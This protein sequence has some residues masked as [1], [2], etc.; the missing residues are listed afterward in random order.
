[1]SDE[2][3]YG[4]DGQTPAVVP[5]VKS[6]TEDELRA[7]VEQLE[8]R[9][10]DSG[11]RSVADVALLELL[12]A[13]RATLSEGDRAQLDQM[14]NREQQTAAAV[15]WALYQA[16]QAKALS[17]EVGELYAQLEAAR[18]G[19]PIGDLYG[20]REDDEGQAEVNARG[21]KLY[22]QLRGI[23]RPVGEDGKP[24]ER[25]PADTIY[26]QLIGKPRT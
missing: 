23:V 16:Q 3:K 20:Q 5:Q 12:E 10:N 18:L 6:L 19:E 21:A 25:T 26:D 4:V 17:V 9:R 1:M 22:D 14:A 8:Q 24:R 7:G 13:Y 15:M 11:A 2:S